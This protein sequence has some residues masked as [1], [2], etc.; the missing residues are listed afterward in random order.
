MSNL[1]SNRGVKNGYWSLAQLLQKY[2]LTT[3]C[4]DN[5]L[6]S[7]GYL[8]ANAGNVPTFLLNLDALVQ[9]VLAAQRTT[10]SRP[11]VEVQVLCAVNGMKQ[12]D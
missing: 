10:P 6:V 9:G 2:L 1:G 4:R 3:R 5:I 7:I 12:V 11:I 8:T